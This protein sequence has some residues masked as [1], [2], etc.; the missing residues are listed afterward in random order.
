MRAVVTNP[1]RFSFSRFAHF[2]FSRHISM[3]AFPTYP[4]GTPGQPW[5]EAE[6][7][8]WRSLQAKKRDYLTNVLH[9]LR[10]ALAQ[11]TSLGA[12]AVLESYGAVDY[13]SVGAGRFELF[14]VRS[15][16]W[17]PGKHTAVITGGVHGY[18]TRKGVLRSKIG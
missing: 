9:P 11:G 16:E 15:K 13:S 3:K 18:E 17:C 1:R 8:Q 2:S 6:R 5:A 10:A 12:V 7:A 14:G 4:I